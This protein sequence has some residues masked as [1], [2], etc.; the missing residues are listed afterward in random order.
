[1]RAFECRRFGFGIVFPFSWRRYKPARDVSFLSFQ[2]L[3]NIFQR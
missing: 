2:F 3:A 1:V